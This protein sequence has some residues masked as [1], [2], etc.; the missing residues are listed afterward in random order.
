LTASTAIAERIL[1]VLVDDVVLHGQPLRMSCSLGIAAGRGSATPEDLCRHADAAMYVAKSRGKT[2][3]EH[4]DEGQH[5][6]VVARGDL[7]RDLRSAAANGELILHYQPIVDLRSGEVLGMEA[8]VRWEHPT[9]GFLLPG[10]FIEAAEKSGSI[11]TIGEWVVDRALADLAALRRSSPRWDAIYV[12]V[13]LSAGQLHSADLVPTVADALDRHGVE[14]FALILEITETV[15]AS[16]ADARA[17]LDELRGIGVRVALDD[18]GTGFSSLQY[19]KEL[20]VDFIKI[21]RSFVTDSAPGSDGAVVLAAIVALAQGLRLE[22]IAEGIEEPDELTRLRALGT[23][24]GQ[25]Y[26][27]ARP[28]PIDAFASLMPEPLKRNGEA[29][30]RV[31]LAG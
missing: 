12:T 21:D 6:T 15:V 5:A 10:E 13:N 23:M 19:L 17:V 30:G 29:G 27:F 4:F 31:R 25:G 8:L 11:V 16:D 24:S 28:A 22:L 14:P 3:F 20:P 9:R 18:F 2:C 26:L 7:K 1:A